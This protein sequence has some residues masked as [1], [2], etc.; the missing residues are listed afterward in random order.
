LSSA[1]AFAPNSPNA[2]INV[3]VTAS[4]QALGP[5]KV[6][7]TSQARFVNSG[8]QVVF[9]DIVSAAASAPTAAVATSMPMLP[10]TVEVFSVPQGAQIAVIAAAVGSTLY[11]T[12][13]DGL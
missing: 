2:T 12:P 10:N 13:G 6:S 9:I 5:L 1:I 3:A 4:S 11:V 8:T 7:S